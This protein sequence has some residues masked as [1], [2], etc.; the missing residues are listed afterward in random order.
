MIE[1][2]IQIRN[3]SKFIQSK[4]IVIRM[5]LDIPKGS[6][7]GLLGPNGAGKTTTLKLL[8]GNLKPSSGSINIMGLDPWKKRVELFKKVGYLP[9][10]PSLHREKTV[11]QFLN[12][13][14]RLKGYPRN[15]SIHMVRDILEQVGLS[16]FE[17][18]IVGKLS[19]GETQRLGFANTLIGDPEI[20]ILDEPTASLDP[21]GRIYVMSLITE[22]AKD[23]ERTVI[24]SSHILPEIQRMTNHIAIM[25]EGK[26][27][28][29]GNM[30]ELTRNVFDDTY[31]IQVSQPMELKAKLD[32]IG[33]ETKIELDTLIVKTNGKISR[34]W[35]EI[36]QICTENG[37]EL[38]S[39]KPV[40]DALESLFINLVSK[41]ITINNSNSSEEVINP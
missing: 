34:L 12:Y 15:D 30:R 39:Y 40:K 1:N 35:K 20:L 41:N 13:M 17:Q 38:K 22:L 18:S 28:I 37:Y 36:P 26:V 31:E 23:K 27:L 7:F 16:R 4:A 5:N 25:S 10:N 21:E 2:V 19:G 6:L 33:Y 9:Q 29:S 8:T 24:V 32:E 14:T 11:F 3:L